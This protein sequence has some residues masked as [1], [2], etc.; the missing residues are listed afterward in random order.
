[1]VALRADDAVEPKAQT[2]GAYIPNIFDDV[3]H[4]TMEGYFRINS[5]FDSTG[6]RTAR[7]A[8]EDDLIAALRSIR[9]AD[10]TLSFTRTGGVLRSY[11]VRCDQAVSFT[12]EEG[13]VKSFIFG[14][15]SAT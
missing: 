5:A 9:R 8:M 6:Y 7:N 11:T 12:G 2:D 4:I 15:V 13:P 1:M 10:G 14:L 3:R